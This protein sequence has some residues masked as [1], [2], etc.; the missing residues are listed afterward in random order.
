M[1][2][3]AAG[4]A[5]PKKIMTFKNNWF[6]GL[7]GTRDLMCLMS[8]FLLLPAL[9]IGLGVCLGRGLL[10]MYAY[11]LSLGGQSRRIAVPK[12][13]HFSVAYATMYEFVL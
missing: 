3:T 2:V 11:Y 9:L 10:A 5:G 1:T 13:N 6:C 8:P 12:S 4:A 7:E